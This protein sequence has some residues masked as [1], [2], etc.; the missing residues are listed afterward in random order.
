MNSSP[1]AG[2]ALDGNF[3]VRIYRMRQ[4]I[5]IFDL[6]GTLV[7]S[8]RDLANGINYVR[9]MHGLDPLPLESITGIVGPGVRATLS[10]ALSDAGKIDLDEVVK[11]YRGFY[12]LHMHDETRLFPGVRPGLERLNA[13]GYSLALFSNKLQHYCVEILRHFGIDGLFSR[14][15]GDGDGVPLKPDPGALLEIISSLGGERRRAWM[16][17]DNHTDLE[18]AR[19]AGIR[20]VFVTYGYGETGGVTPDF[21]ASSFEEVAGL[22]ISGSDVCAESGRRRS[23]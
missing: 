22:F 23:E 13:S 9:G 16:I 7:D 14:V 10:R 21:T 8:Q 4:D 1:P 5:L 19:R 18:A 11:H 17:G 6:D 20:S 12:R 15:V 2:A 3:P